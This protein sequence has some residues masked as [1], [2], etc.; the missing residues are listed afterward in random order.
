MTNSL[1]ATII[2]IVVMMGVLQG[3]CAYLIYVE[4]KLAAY[5]QDRIGPNRVGPFGLLQPI[6]DGL[7]FLFKEEVIPGHVDIFLFLLAPA[8]AVGT[9]TLAFAVVPF[10]PT[11]LTGGDP[12]PYQFVIAPGVDIGILFVFAIGSLAVYGIILGG[13]ASNNKYSFLGALRS[14]AQIVSYEIPLGMSI[15]GVVIFAGSLNLERIIDDQVHHGW[16]IFY[17]PLAFVLFMASVLAEC[18]RLPFDLPEAEQEL[19]GGYHTEYSALKFGLF[20]LGEYTHVITTSLILSILF[21]GGWHF[22]WITEVGGF[23]GIV[24]KV[25]VIWAKALG[26]ILF[27]MLIRWTIPRFR[28][29]QLMGLAWKVLIPLALFNLLAVIAVMETHASKWWLLPISVLLVVGAAAF[30]LTLPAGPKRRMDLVARQ[31]QSAAVA[32]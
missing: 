26:F 17:Q 24:L 9:A 28:F 23:A 2:T 8:V 31:E 13:Y 16:N 12:L 11:T 22:P 4:R 18:N 29:D 25:L 7:K 10:G 20:F 21:L 14:S 27:Y 15:L 6:A 30:S 32:P 19:I 5:M 1:L 3:A